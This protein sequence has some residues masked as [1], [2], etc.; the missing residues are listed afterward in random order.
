MQ[1]MFYIVVKNAFLPEWPLSAS[2]G[3]QA[4]LAD[5]CLMRIG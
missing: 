3:C 4:L 2:D 1:S 5:S